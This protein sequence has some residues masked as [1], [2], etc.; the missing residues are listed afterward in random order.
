MD[1][2]EA[3][4]LGIVQGITEWLPISST[5]HLRIVPTLM[6]K[7]DP[8]AAFTA[9]IQFGTLL[10]ALIY[11]RKDLLNALKGWCRSFRGDKSVDAKMGWAV[12]VGTLPIVIFGLAFK[13]QIEGNL[14]SL[15]VVAFALIGM[16]VL[17]MVAERFGS[18]T[19]QYKD[20]AEKDGFLIG[21]WQAVALIPGA[22]RSGST[23]TGAL[24][25]G[26]DRATAARFSFLLSMPSIFAAGAYALYK[27][28]HQILG[29]NLTPTLV[30]TVVSFFV[31]YASI[32]FLMKYLQTRSVW[33]FVAY[34][35]ILG[36]VLLVLINQGTLTPLAGIH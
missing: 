28:R 27:E 9:V 8:G 17:M 18:K 2:V 13:D 6:G 25:A 29:T 33:P 26:F 22:S 32:A 24:F 21:L 16:G 36:I 12:F 30:A 15:T 1:L 19:R 23:M 7:P 4:I 5:A 20:I 31:G 3:I 10:A 14:R 35:V 11:F 34:R